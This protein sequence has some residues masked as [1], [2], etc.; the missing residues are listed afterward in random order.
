M[1][2]YL[3]ERILY[4][5][6]IATPPP[7]DLCCILVIP[8]YD[9]E[10]VRPLASLAQCEAPSGTVELIILINEAEVAD[11]SITKANQDL[12][13]KLTS[14]GDSLPVW[15]HLHVLYIS[16]LPRKH[17]GVGLARKIAMDEATQRF[18]SLGRD[19]LIINLDA[20]CEVLPNYFTAIENH[21]DHHPEAWSAGVSYQHKSEELAPE[22]P[23]ILYELHLRYFVALQR[24]AGLPFAYQTLG[25]CMVVRSSAYQ[26]MGGMNKRKAGEDFYF[27]QKFIEVGRHQEIFA[28]MVVPS[29]RVSDR[30]PF[31]TG[32]AI[33]QMESGLVQMTTAWQVFIPVKKMLKKLGALLDDESQFSSID[34]PLHAFLINAGVHE[35]LEE[36]KSNTSSADERVKRFLKWFNAFRVMKYAHFAREFIPDIPVRDLPRANFPGFGNDLNNFS[37]AD[38]LE[39]LRKQEWNG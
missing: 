28:T 23:I 35:K 3:K 13:E 4:P 7:V 18:E 26:K 24:W 33:G 34:E 22:A 10:E 14:V 20:D 19:G 17:A 6:L 16:D 32:K 8:C 38:L 27:L 11:A 36:I 29:G 21:F 31:G 5:P 12:H 2:S 9:E 1:R 39:Y 25:S 37:A 30:V 15:L